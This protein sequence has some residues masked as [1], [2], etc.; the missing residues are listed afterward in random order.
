MIAINLPEKALYT[1]IDNITEVRSDHNDRLEI[2]GI[3]VNQFIKRAKLPRQ[4]V[5]E[6]VS[7]GLPVLNSKISS[8]V[9]MGESH[10]VAKPLVYMAQN[11]SL[12][13]EFIALYRELNDR[14]NKVKRTM[15]GKN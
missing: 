10:Q 15:R 11:H 6:L 4:L 12:T 14:R 1:L 3:V 9:K 5:E 8:S 7:E 2:E 13:R